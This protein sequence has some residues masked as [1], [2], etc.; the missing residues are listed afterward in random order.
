MC[1]Q[2]QDGRKWDRELREKE[3][4]ASPFPESTQR[5]GTAHKTGEPKGEDRS[6]E[7]EPGEEDRT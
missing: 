3:H 7:R 6:R 5:G 1:W 4:A 2:L